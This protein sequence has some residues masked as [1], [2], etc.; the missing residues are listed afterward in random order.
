MIWIGMNRR[1]KLLVCGWDVSPSIIRLVKR[2]AC[3]MRPNGGTA[4]SMAWGEYKRL[5]MLWYDIA[6]DTRRCNDDGILIKGSSLIGSLKPSEALYAIA[7][8]V[9]MCNQAGIPAMDVLKPAPE[10]LKQKVITMIKNNYEQ[11]KR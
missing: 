2:M 11:N 9:Q 8:A 5:L 7:A 3:V 1:H 6:V 4:Y 10:E